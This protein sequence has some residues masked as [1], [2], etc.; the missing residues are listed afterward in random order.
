[1]KED[2]FLVLQDGSV[3][4]GVSFGEPPYRVEQFRTN[5]IYDKGAG[6]VVFNTGM[7]GYHEIITDPSY[8][9]QIV[10]M[11]YP[12]IGNYGSSD[13]WSEIGP[14]QDKRSSVKVAGLVV[15]SISRGSVPKERKSL[16][17]FLKEGKTQ[18][19]SEVDTRALTLK[20]RDSGSLNGII[21]RS[22]NSAI[23][24]DGELKI[25]LEYLNTFPAMVGRNLVKTVGTTTPITVNEKGSAAHFVLLDSGIKANIIRELIDLDCKVTLLPYTSTTEEIKNARADAVL[26]SNG[27]G[28]PAVLD[29]AVAVTASLVG[30]VPLFGICLGNQLISLALG[31][32]TYK[33]KFGHHGVNHPVRDEFTKKVFV[34]SQ[35]HG[36]A[37]DADT[38]PKDVDVWFTNANDGSLEGIVHRTLPIMSAQFHPEAAPGPRDGIW[39]FKA[40][41]E[42][43]EKSR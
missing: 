43:M 14:E 22:S 28:D 23:L 5:E 34:T 35:N 27:P 1:M 21:V 3:F 18:G 24:S 32:K 29:H 20:L 19:I 36:F 12:H 40:F 42:K 39:I 17:Q 9:G 15:R 4:P 30:S 41:I 10:V 26:I 37:V 7:T 8:T 2:S 13:D 25:C 38:L 33:M 11:T 6:E 31:A 16:D